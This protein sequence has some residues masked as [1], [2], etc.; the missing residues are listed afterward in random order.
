MNHYLRPRVEAL[1]SYIKD[2]VDFINKINGI[3]NITDETFLDTLDVKPLY[4][5]IP[6]HEGI[7]AA[8]EALKSVPKKPIATKVIIK[9]LFLTLT[10]NIFIF[11][12]IPSKTRMCHGNYM[13]S[14]LCKYFY[15]KI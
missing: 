3:E 1:P 4:T 8:K 10:L 15:G 2:T 6:N 14:K 11:N 9:F 7:E 12:G 13:C 5:N